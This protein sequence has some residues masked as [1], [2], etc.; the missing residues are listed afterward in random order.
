MKIGGINMKTAIR[1]KRQYTKEDYNIYKSLEQSL[2]EVKLIKEGKIK[3][4]TWREILE[5]IERD[6]N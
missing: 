2:A 3:A 6:E 1:L 4:K 5:E